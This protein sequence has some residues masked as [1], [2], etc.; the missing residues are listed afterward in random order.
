MSR[1]T[2]FG[3]FVVDLMAR[4]PHLPVPGET[5]KG[6]MFR[7]GPGGKGFNQAVAAHKA[8][9]EV[10]VVTKL[11]RDSFAAVA[12]DTMRELGMDASRVLYSED[13]PT[14]CALISVDEKTGQNE[15]VI[16]PGALN[17]ISPEETETLRGLL[18]DS[19]YV[20]LQLEVNQDANERVAGLARETGCKVI[21]N[22][23]PYSP[24]TDAFLSLCAMVT[25]NETEAEA[26][27]GVHVET[28]EDAAEAAAYFHERGVETVL[29]TLGQRGVFFSMQGEHK[30]I[31]A[32]EVEAVDT[33]GAGDAFNG[34]LLAGL[35][36]QMKLPEAIRFGQ[37]TAALSVQ[38]IGT[39]P[40]MPARAEIDA[41]LREHS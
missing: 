37:A 27:T 32:F 13:A 17:T 23:A 12:E 2:V 5:V 19:E 16:V 30:R 31:P 11:G 22:S 39:T 1:V 24:V 29:I 36:E 28:D 14:G 18:A 38:K 7:L 20:L 15:I 33:T 6:T 9:A 10:T 25:P 26:L 40:A 35:A 4:T 34:G 41:F 21:L 8:G 3:S